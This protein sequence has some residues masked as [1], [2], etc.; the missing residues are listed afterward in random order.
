[1]RLLLMFATTVC[2]LLFIKLRWPKK[3]NFYVWDENMSHTTESVT[4]NLR[5]IYIVLPNQVIWR[6]NL[7][8]WEEKF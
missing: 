6:R 2:G 5:N 7:E 8:D 4:H 1:M 3:K